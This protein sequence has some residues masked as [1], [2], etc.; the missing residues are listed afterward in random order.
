MVQ[1]RASSS[2]TRLSQPASVSRAT[3]PTR[4]LIPGEHH[5]SALFPR[6]FEQL[7]QVIA[8]KIIGPGV[9]IFGDGPDGGREATYEGP[10]T[11]PSTEDNWD[12]YVVVQAKF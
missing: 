2:V 9:V 11:F 1:R 10:M 8:S 4:G 3:T 5:I 7:T 12:G 6:S